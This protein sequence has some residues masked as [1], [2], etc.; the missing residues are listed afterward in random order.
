MAIQQQVAHVE[1]QYGRYICQECNDCGARVLSTVKWM[2]KDG[3][4]ECPHCGHPDATA[5]MPCVLDSVLSDSTWKP[6][7]N[8][9]LELV[10]QDRAALIFDEGVYRFVGSGSETGGVG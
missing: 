5:W 4:D 8:E 9:A 1:E 7:Y 2:V 3:I 6:E 10:E